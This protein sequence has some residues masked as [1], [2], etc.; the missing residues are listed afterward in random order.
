MM[1]G[2][3]VG[4]LLADADA[5]R[6]PPTFMDLL[7]LVGLHVVILGAGCWA[8]RRRMLGTSSVVWGVGISVSYIVGLVGCVWALRPE[9]ILKFSVQGQTVDSSAAG[10]RWLVRC[11]TFVGNSAL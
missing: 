5:D 9:L 3:A 7:L 6:P 4:S 1:L 8:A 2:I 10:C 11:L